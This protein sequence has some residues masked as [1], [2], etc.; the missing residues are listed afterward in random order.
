M[1][2]DRGFAKSYWI[3]SKKHNFQ[4]L[5]TDR[6]Q[7]AVAV[8][9]ARDLVTSWMGANFG[10]QDEQE[11]ELPIKVLSSTT[12]GLGANPTEKFG[13]PGSS[14][15]GPNNGANVGTGSRKA[16]EKL[17]KSTQKMQKQRQHNNNNNSN[18]SNNNSTNIANKKH[19]NV[20][21]PMRIPNEDDSEEEEESRTSKTRAVKRVSALDAYKQSK[22]KRKH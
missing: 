9:D 17:Q 8:Q 11:E 10:A 21:P 14:N 2:F 3:M 5:D 16:L 22:K 18:T 20:R 12:M 4:K 19:Q 13:G 7:F 15:S 6:A 1:L